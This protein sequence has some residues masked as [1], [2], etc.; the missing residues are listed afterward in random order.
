MY[1]LKTRPIRVNGPIYY[2]I[3]FIWSCVEQKAQ[4]IE[5]KSRRFLMEGVKINF[6]TNHWLNISLVDNLDIHEDKHNFLQS[7]I[8]DFIMNKNWHTPHSII[9]NYSNI[10]SV[11]QDVHVPSFRMDDKLF[12]KRT[13]NGS[14]AIERWQVSLF[15]I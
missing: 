8:K 11:F 9:L 13:N 1:L 10:I 6:Q 15:H 12:W 4:I 2:H 3:F 14:F 5:D 7:S